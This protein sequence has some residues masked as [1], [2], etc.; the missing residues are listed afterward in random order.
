[1]VPKFG[2]RPIVVIEQGGIAERVFN[3]V[4]ETI[5]NMT[6]IEA[7]S[8]CKPNSYREVAKEQ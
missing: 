3:A 4:D 8:C 5:N 1:M 2:N 7:F 6:T